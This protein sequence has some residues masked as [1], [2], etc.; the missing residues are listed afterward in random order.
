MPAVL[1][2]IGDERDGLATTLAHVRNVFRIA[3]Y[4]LHDDE[5]RR[6]PTPSAFTMAALVHHMVSV[7]GMWAAVIDRRSPHASLEAD[8]PI[9]DLLADYER[10]CRET[11]EAV[12]SVDD[13][14]QAAPL[15]ADARWAPRDV[16]GYTVRWVVLHLIQE[17]ARHAGHA[18]MLRE[19]IDGAT[20][21][22]LMA[23]AEQWP[24]RRTIKPWTRAT[25]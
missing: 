17:T 12:A 10:A 7:E 11:D 19:A 23:A 1:R 5:A 8:A 14:S 24:P 3:A 9:T 13:L 16:D 21:L 15:P 4:G 22:P 25:P 18:D 6:R 20:L 2:P